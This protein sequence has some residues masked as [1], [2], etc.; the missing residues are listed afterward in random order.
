MSDL[1]LRNLQQKGLILEALELK[2]KL[3]G[4]VVWER[5]RCGKH[6][7]RKCAQGILHGP[8]PYLHFYSAGKVR[9]KYLI[10]SLG[11]LMS[12]SK[13]ELEGMLRDSE[14]AILG[15]GEG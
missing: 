5:V 12:H 10:R 2:Q 15:Q 13:E 3:K 9:R 14:S 11:E 1:V 6:G 4:S 8:Y 7:C